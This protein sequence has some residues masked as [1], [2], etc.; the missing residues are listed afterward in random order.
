[1]VLNQVPQCENTVRNDYSPESAEWFTPNADN[2]VAI[3]TDDLSLKD[4][5]LILTVTPVAEA[6]PNEI[7][8]DPID[9]EITFL[10]PTSN[11][12]PF[13]AELPEYE[14]EV[15]QEAILKLASG[16]TWTYAFPEVVDLDDDKEPS[17]TVLMSKAKKFAKYD[18][19]AREI[20][21][22][23]QDANKM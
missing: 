22:R 4:Q 1:M 6:W 20:Y 14:I 5:T 18:E 12:P 17:M 10:A 2:S 13:F 23:R 21:I 19:E 15:S 7:E 16:E 11:K 8:S 3:R 9:Y